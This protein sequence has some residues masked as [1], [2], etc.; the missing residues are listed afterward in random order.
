MSARRGRGSIRHSDRHSDEDLYDGMNCPPSS[1]WL[2][3]LVCL[4][5]WVAD[6]TPHLY[7][8]HES[9][10]WIVPGKTMQSKLRSFANN[11][12]VLSIAYFYSL[13]LEDKYLIKVDHC[14]VKWYMSII[15]ISIVTFLTERIIYHCHLRIDLLG[16]FIYQITWS[17]LLFSTSL[18]FC[19]DKGPFRIYDLGGG[20]GGFDPD[21]R[22]KTSAPAKNVGWILIPPP[23]KSDR[24]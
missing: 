15:I 3:I 18:Y 20:G 9:K 7:G 21:G 13:G 12:E 5:V 19:L 2:W 11:G 6:L 23:K 10:N 8:W 22:S 17:R 14:R 4:T 1:D 24:N 16:G